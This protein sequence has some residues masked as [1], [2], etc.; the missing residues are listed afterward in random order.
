MN[1][2]VVESRH[3]ELAVEIDYARF[4]VFQARD[5]VARSDRDNYFIARGQRLRARA[6]GITGVDIAV[7]QN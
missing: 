5:F 6:A 7:E 2:G 4:R 1:V 3:G